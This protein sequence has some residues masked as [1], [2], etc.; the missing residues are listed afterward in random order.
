MK[1][2][3]FGIKTNDSNT[4]QVAIGAPLPIRF[5]WLGNFRVFHSI[6]TQL[7][8]RLYKLQILVLKS[9]RLYLATFS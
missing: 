4:I 7:S 9:E 3:D 5:W 6:K 1:F 8:S 2:G